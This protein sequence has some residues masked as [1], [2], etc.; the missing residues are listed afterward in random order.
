[1]R[2][3]AA[4][5][6]LLPGLA[7]AQS[8]QVPVGPRAIALGGAFS[9]IADD[10]SALFWNPAGLARVG[11]QEIA[12]THADLFGSGIRDNLVSFVLPLSPRQA[13]AADWYHSGFDDDELGFGENRLDFAWSV[14]AASWLY[15]GA[16]LK[17]LNRTTSLDGSTVRQG[18]GV[19]ADLGLLAAPGRPWRLAL[20]AQDLF[21]TR[22]RD[23]EG[24]A[25]VVYPRNLRAG[26]SYS[27]ERLGTLALDLDD[28]WHLGVEA[29]PHELVALRGGVQDDTRGDEPPSW[30]YGLGLKA[31]LFR[32]DW[33]RQHHP[34]LEATDHFG[35]GMAFNFN[36]AQIRIEK[37]EAR[38]LYTSQIKRYAREPFGA[39]QVRNLLDTPLQAQ[40]SVFVPNLMEAPSV[41]P[42][43]LRPK[44]VQE[45]PLTAVFSDRALAHGEDR[46][47]QVEV[48]AS[49]PSR[50]LV[51]QDRAGARCVAYAPGAIDWGAGVEQAAAFVTTRDPVVEALAREASRIVVGMEPDPFGNRNL[52]F[53]AAMTDALAAL[54]ITYVP[55]PNNPYSA[56]SET[57]HAVDTVH[58]PYET[59]QS[60]TGDC[61]DTTVLMAALLEN[62][63]VRTKLVDVPGHLSLLVSTGVHERHRVALGVDERLAVIADEEAWIP[64]ETTELAGGFAHA[65][66]VG[67]EAYAGWQTRGQVQLVDVAEAQAR[68]EPVLPPARREPPRLDVSA[69]RER[70]RQDAAKVSEWRREFMGRRFGDVQGDLARSEPAE[71]QV[72]EVLLLAG[73]LDEAESRLEALRAADS[74]S[75]RVLN[76]LAVVA[77][78]RGDLGA[79]ALHLGRALAHDPSDP[80]IWLNLGLVRWAQGDS[81]AA[82]QPL[83]RALA[84]AGGLEGAAARMNRGGATAEEARL[85]LG[86]IVGRPPAAPGRPGD[87]PR[88]S[89]RARS[90]PEWSAWP[91]RVEPAELSARIAGF[92]YWRK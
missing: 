76:D 73:S 85:L 83:R 60:R 27:L 25:G 45:I 47:V 12:A 64:L 14:R 6:L 78:A 80:G 13:V 65:W 74:T 21:D 18:Q 7:R 92:L 77:A 68:F 19:G 28:R 39:V 56:I 81:L 62:V 49:Y 42:V 26:A 69:L 82:A 44:A 3:A 20:V 1:V 86:A 8:E 34:T 4:L 58:Y 38:D 33:A 87:G 11:N 2:L 63:G 66:R 70:L 36:P 90:E 24:G 31:G 15:A 88:A 35:L 10:G 23:A 57:A 59:L 61:D 54:G 16:T 50:R 5:V 43:L 53:A 40:V 55:D 37:V 71:V 72:A 79:A 41:Q 32:L 9:A 75:A 51:R 91:E 22:I 48:R 84:L 67:A 17:Y 30:S 29:Y 46:P 89:D 52:G